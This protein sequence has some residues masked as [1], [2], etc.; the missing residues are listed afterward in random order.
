MRDYQ[1]ISPCLEGVLKHDSLLYDGIKRPIELLKVL[2]GPQSRGTDKDRLTRLDKTI[3]ENEK[4]VLNQYFQ[5][6][7]SI[8]MKKLSY[9]VVED[10]SG[11]DDTIKLQAMLQ[12]MIKIKR[13]I[14][15]GS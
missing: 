4:K 14:V 3:D 11:S 8:F 9:F 15:H 2:D 5:D 7:Y 10:L 1:I 13:L 12:E 6:L